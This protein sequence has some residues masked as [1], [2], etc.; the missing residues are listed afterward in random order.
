MA[1]RITDFLVGVSENPQKLRDYKADP[2]QVLAQSNLTQ[3]ER[4]LVKGGGQ[5]LRQA[6]KQEAGPGAVVVLW[7]A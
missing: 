4:A 7:E 5:A 1:R 2:D 3:Q 6:V